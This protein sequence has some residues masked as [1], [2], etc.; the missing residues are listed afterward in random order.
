MELAENYRFL[1]FFNI[2]IDS[3]LRGRDLVKMKVI[4]VMASGQ[5]KE[6][7]SV[8]RSGIR[9]PRFLPFPAAQCLSG[10]LKPA[11]NWSLGCSGA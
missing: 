2:A 8:L 7:A 6:P 5:I 4:D 1:A 10:G 11:G 3:K 9:A